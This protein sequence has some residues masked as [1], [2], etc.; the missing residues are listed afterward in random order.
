MTT[1]ETLLE[2]EFKTP[3]VRVQ[4]TVTKHLKREV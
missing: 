3:V 2:A 1:P 4:K